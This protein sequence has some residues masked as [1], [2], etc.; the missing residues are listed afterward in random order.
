MS[1]DAESL[2]IAVL[3]SGRGSNLQALIDAMAD[4]SMPAHIAVVLSNNADAGG[5]QRAK[6][7]GIPVEVLSH[8]D[9]A[10][11]ESYDNALYAVLQRYEPG[12]V[13]LAGCD[14]AAAPVE[15]DLEHAFFR[16]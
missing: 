2:P 11:R 4:G 7:A 6:D 5:L 13:V 14:V 9:Y 8:R 3:I 1:T 15:V 12:L 10:D 16:F